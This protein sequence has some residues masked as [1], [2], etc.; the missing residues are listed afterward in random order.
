M[1]AH[2]PKREKKGQYTC[3]SCYAYQSGETYNTWMYIADLIERQI[4]KSQTQKKFTPVI[5][6]EGDIHPGNDCDD[7]YDYTAYWG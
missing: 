3:K 2:Y 4:F 6:Q 7:H 1:Y 5:T